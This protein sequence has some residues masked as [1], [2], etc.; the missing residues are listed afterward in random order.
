MA[1]L[2]W[3][4]SQKIDTTRVADDVQIRKTDSDA[5]MLLFRIYIGPFQKN[6]TAFLHARYQLE[7]SIYE[8]Q[9]EHHYFQGI[10]QALLHL[11]VELSP[12]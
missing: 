7:I 5:G 8:S 6:H 2:A 3:R 12:L 11:L 9:V 4:K 1:Y 10:G